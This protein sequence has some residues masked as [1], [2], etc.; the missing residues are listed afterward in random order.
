MNFTFTSVFH[1][2]QCPDPMSGM[3]RYDPK[4]K[5]KM[6]VESDA[7]QPCKLY[8]GKLGTRGQVGMQ[9]G[10]TRGEKKTGRENERK[11]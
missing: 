1:I 11:E 6:Q 9:G 3:I 8:F 2:D 10:R 4:G 5:I 7:V